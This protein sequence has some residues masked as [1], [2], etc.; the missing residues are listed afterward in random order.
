MSQ[1]RTSE[2]EHFFKENYSRFY[3]FALH[4]VDNEEVS[5][6]IVNDAFEFAWKNYKKTE[7]QN[8][9][10]YIYSFIRNKCVDY[11]RH[12]IVKNKYA[13]IYLQITQ[14]AEDQDYEE[15]DERIEIIRQILATLSPQ[16]RLVL[17]ECYINRK[18]YKE[19]AD[20]LEISPNTVK[21]HIVKALKKIRE[22]ISKKKLI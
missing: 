8:L 4:L 19:V 17:Q 18:K 7:I 15:Y 20:D 3:Y 21:K 14:E 6:D 12:E 5:R 1:N 2:F 16:T 11:I 9:K 10:T 22:E 13:D